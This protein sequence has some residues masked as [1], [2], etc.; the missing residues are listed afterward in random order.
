MYD[1]A[2]FNG[3]I[4]KNKELIKTNVYIK[5]G[6]IQA[7]SDA[8][9]A[10]KEY[11]DCNNNLVLPGLVDPHVHFDLDLG[12]IRSKDDF[13]SGTKSA[14]YGGV[15]TIIDFLSPVSNAKDLE[16]ALQQRLVEA[17]D[18]NI[19]YLFHA[20]LMNPK[21]EVKNLVNKIKELQLHSVKIFTTYSDSNRRTYDQE[22]KELL[23]ESKK[24]GI[25]VLA[26]IEND[27]M[28]SLNDE[29]TYR[30]LPTSRPS[31]SETSE[32]LKLAKLVEETNTN[33]YMVH[34]SSGETLRQLKEQY[35][36]ILNKQLYIESC[37]H[38]FSFNHDVLTQEDGYLYTMAPPLRR[39]E[40]REL[41]VKNIDSVYTI[42]TD[43]CSF[44]SSDKLGKPLSK[45]PLGIGG[46]EH[47]FDVMFSKFGLD[48]VDKMSINPAKIYGLYPQKGIIEI[49]SD[50]DIFIYQECDTEI[51]DFHGKTDYSLYLEMK[52]KGKVKST[53]SRGK[54]VLKDGEFIKNR[55]SYLGGLYEINH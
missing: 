3:R 7:F 18:S 40:E 4:Y 36:G 5:D 22:I 30:D 31:L 45:M 8:L 12:F 24:Q 55:G 51:T 11:Y 2:L 42:G 6:V 54:F 37:P 48:I 1:L 32:A 46:V 20:T 38:Y 33:L 52:K 21:N 34:L 23:I 50:A 39:E 28:I 19:D 9:L 14:A 29:M 15:T 25:V 41:L 26:H 44:N 53:L 17:K 10:S 16:D 47:S 43:H 35:S 13:Y 49:G 27:E